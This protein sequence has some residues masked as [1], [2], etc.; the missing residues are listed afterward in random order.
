MGGGHERRGEKRD[1]GMTLPVG[2]QAGKR[3]QLSDLLQFVNPDFKREDD[4]LTMDIEAAKTATKASIQ[5]LAANW[6]LQAK[7]R[8][9]STTSSTARSRTASSSSPAITLTSSSTDHLN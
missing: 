5:A 6:A 7:L 1:Q 2:K 4:R 8:K 9:L 3:T